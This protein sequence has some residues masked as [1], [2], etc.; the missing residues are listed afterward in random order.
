MEKFLKSLLLFFLFPFCVEEKSVTERTDMRA[1]MITL[2]PFLHFHAAAPS[3][4][5]MSFISRFNHVSML[6]QPY[7]NALLQSCFSSASTLWFS[8]IFLRPLPFDTWILKW[9]SLVRRQSNMPDIATWCSKVCFFDWKFEGFLLQTCSKQHDL[10][11]HDYLYL[12]KL[13]SFTIFFTGDFEFLKSA[14]LARHEDL[15][16]QFPNTWYIVERYHGFESMESK[17]GIKEKR[18]TWKSHEIRSRGFLDLLIPIFIGSLVHI[19]VAWR[20]W[21][22]LQRCLF[23]PI[24]CVCWAFYSLSEFILSFSV[25]SQYFWSNS[26]SC[27]L[28]VRATPFL[29]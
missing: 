1:A 19:H 2:P 22:I 6:L 8:I 21:L 15:R 10:F 25:S 12:K 27:L 17:V 20:D 9:H 28:F 18:A 13:M 26:T 24:L 11:L 29:L 14:K 5:L 3:L 7:F 4:S 23:L 16:S